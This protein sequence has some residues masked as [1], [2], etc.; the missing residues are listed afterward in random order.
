M[1]SLKNVR[2]YDNGGKTF[3]RYTAVYMDQPEY[4]PGT[5]AARGMST[6]PFS[7]QGFGCS[8]VA[9]PG[10]HLGKRIKFEELPP[11][12]QRLVLQDISTEETA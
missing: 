10:R 7:P 11:D 8:C 1:N 6:N 4:Q 5:F 9:S 12:C 3:D 2:I